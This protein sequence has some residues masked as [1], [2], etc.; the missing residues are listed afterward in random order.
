MKKLLFL[1]NSATYVHE[2]PQTLRHLSEMLGYTLEVAQLTPGGYTL[3]QHADAESDHGRLVLQ[4]IGKGYDIVF[5]QDNGNCIAD[6][7]HL[8]ACQRACE[9]LAGEIRKSGAQMWFYVRPPYGYEKFGRTPFEQCRAFDELFTGLAEQ[10]GANCVFVNRAFAEAMKSLPFDLWGADHGHTS[11]HGAYLAVCVFFA[12]LFKQSAIKL[13]SNGL[14]DGDA[15]A[16]QAVADR[17]ALD[18]AIP[19]ETSLGEK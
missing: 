6:G 2:I 16:L 17:I 9:T 3:A 12:T 18:R 8:M 4:E 19:W 13:G 1:G 14:P 5:L 15:R 11:D 10:H 7:K